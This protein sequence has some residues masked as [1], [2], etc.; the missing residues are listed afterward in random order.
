[1]CPNCFKSGNHFWNFLHWLPIWR[2]WMGTPYFYWSHLVTFKFVHPGDSSNFARSILGSEDIFL[3]SPGAP[4]G[5]C[6]SMK[7]LVIE[8]LNGWNSTIS[9]IQR[10]HPAPVLHIYL[11][12]KELANDLNGIFTRGGLRCILEVKT[13]PFWTWCSRSL[14]ILLIRGLERTG[15]VRCPWCPHYTRISITSPSVSPWKAFNKG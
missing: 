12:N 1:M 3:I 15:S 14:F 7:S 2:L 8:T 9:S 4:P 10:Y 5:Q 6:W 11:S 13:V